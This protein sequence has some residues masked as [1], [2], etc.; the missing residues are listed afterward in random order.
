MEDPRF[1]IYPVNP[2]RER[3][4]S[5]ILNGIRKRQEIGDSRS[6]ENGICDFE[7]FFKCRIEE[8]KSNFD[9]DVKAGKVSDGIK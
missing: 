3:G 4:T 2:N 5:S 7:R 8:E 6:N 1:K 9:G